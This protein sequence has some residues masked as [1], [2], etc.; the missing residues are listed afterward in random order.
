MQNQ[1]AR[2]ITG[3]AAST[4]IES[5][6]LEA[7]LVPISVRH[8]AQVAIVSERARRLP[9]SDPLCISA[10][11]YTK[12]GRLKRRGECWQ[13]AGDH[14]LASLNLDPQRLTKTGKPKAVRRTAGHSIHNRE[15]LLFPAVAPWSTGNADKI[16]FHLSVRG[17]CDKSS[18]MEE[19]KRATEETL[20]GVRL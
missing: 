20:A 17:E 19:K 18:S 14:V 12:P 15:K 7:N 5:L 1:A 10:T 4:K 13:G 9:D 3:C 2:V 16:R 6:L 8:D 11:S